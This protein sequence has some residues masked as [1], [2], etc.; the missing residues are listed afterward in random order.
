MEQTTLSLGNLERLSRNWDGRTCEILLYM[1]GSGNMFG[2]SGK[3]LH[4]TVHGENSIKDKGTIEIIGATQFSYN[5]ARGANGPD[6]GWMS[7]YKGITDLKQLDQPNLQPTYKVTVEG[8]GNG[9]DS[10]M[11]QI[12]NTK[13]DWFQKV[14]V[15]E[16]NNFVQ[17]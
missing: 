14:K 4:L 3:M 11:C 7:Y 2:G 16:V 8:S 9:T 6:S 10:A 1:T 13:K 15:L 17:Q 5:I 12:L